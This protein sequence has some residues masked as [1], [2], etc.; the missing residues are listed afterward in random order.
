MAAKDRTRET[1]AGAPPDPPRRPISAT[2]D[3]PRGVNALALDRL[4]SAPRSRRACPLTDS[5]TLRVNDSMA[6]SAATPATT[7]PTSRASRRGE[8]LYRQARLSAKARPAR[9]RRLTRAALGATPCRRPR[10][11]LGGG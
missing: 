4:R 10:A 5:C 9:E 6:T 8:R 3:S 2:I 7:E 11:R 1:S